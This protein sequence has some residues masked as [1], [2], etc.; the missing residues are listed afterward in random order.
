M[1]APLAPTPVAAPATAQPYVP[2]DARAGHLNNPKPPY[3]LL[4]R[5]RGLQGLTVLTVE[6]TEDGRPLS[7]HIKRES[8]H[9][10]LDR[11]AVNTVKTWRFVPARRGGRSVRARVEIP[12]RF[13]LSRG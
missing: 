11:A 9:A 4:A 7:I 12:I 2:P 8:G 1:A 6:V 13:E 10:M 3:P 5:R